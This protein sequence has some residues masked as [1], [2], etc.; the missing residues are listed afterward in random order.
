M[1]L[2]EGERPT[3]NGMNI[4]LQGLAQKNP[5]ESRIGEKTHGKNMRG[6]R[7]KKG[8]Q[9]PKSREKEEDT[10]ALSPIM[11]I[12]S[13]RRTTE[14]KEGGREIKNMITEKE[15]ITQKN[16]KKR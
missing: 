9:D 1:D 15:D 8:E 10:E 5:G 13:I 7:Q 4:S 2:E 14:M 16:M 12:G 6:R 11:R 3:R